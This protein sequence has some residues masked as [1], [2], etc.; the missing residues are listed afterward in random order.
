MRNFVPNRVPII[1]HR[2]NPKA[3]VHRAK[4]KAHKHRA[5]KGTSRR[6]FFDFFSMGGR[7]WCRSLFFLLFLL[8]CKHGS[9]SAQ[10]NALMPTGTKASAQIQGRERETHMLFGCPFGKIF[11]NQIFLRYTFKTTFFS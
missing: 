2:P 11:K 6:G 4:G 3:I 9:K 1:V 8:G 7:I 10:S 5:R